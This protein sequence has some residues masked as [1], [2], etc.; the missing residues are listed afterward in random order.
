VLFQFR[1]SRHFLFFA[2][3]LLRL[4]SEGYMMGCEIKKS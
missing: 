3:E 2:V 4:E 1:S